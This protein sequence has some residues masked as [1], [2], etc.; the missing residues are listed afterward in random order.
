MSQGFIKKYKSNL[1]TIGFSFYINNHS[2]IS[3]FKLFQSGTYLFSPVGN[4][5]INLCLLMNNL[6]KIDYMHENIF[7]HQLT[8][9]RFR[10]DAL[11]NSNNTSCEK[12][13]DSLTQ[14]SSAHVTNTSNQQNTMK[15]SE[16]QDVNSNSFSSCFEKTEV[17]TDSGQRY[18]SKSEITK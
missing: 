4:I 17:N 16:S 8:S 9:K 7:A 12:F 15:L 3:H 1:D 6:N 18:I 2:S 14:S 10:L 5:S 11:C 13:H